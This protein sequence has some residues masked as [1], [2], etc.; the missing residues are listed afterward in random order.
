M[1][2]A[3]PWATIMA[4][5]TSISMAEDLLKLHQ[6]LSAAFPIGGFAYSQGLEE[7]MARGI[8]RSGG[9]VACW[10]ER[11]LQ[12]GSPRM[13]AVI[14]AHARAGH[15]PEALSDLILSFAS[16]AERETELQDQGRAFCS[17]MS[18]ITG[19]DMPQRPYPVAL[20]L[21]T[22]GLDVR[23][24]DVLALFLLGAATQMVSAATRFLPLGQTEAQAMLSRLAPQ[25]TVLAAWAATAPLDSLATFTPGADMAA[26]RH[27][28]LEVR[29]FRT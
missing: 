18:G 29:I 23:T 4:M 19:H 3:A 8:L 1:A 10:V 17:L 7:P 13:D 12:H 2:M 25:I 28:T 15:D 26:M 22:A 21:A 14:L 24:E 6:W 20:G 9:D 11:V 27:E 16:C 5:V